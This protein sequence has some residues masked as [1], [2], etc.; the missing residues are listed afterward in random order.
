[1]TGKTVRL[2]LGLRLCGCF[3]DFQ[4]K[5]PS[6]WWKAG[7]TC[8]RTWVEN[9]NLAGRNLSLCWHQEVWKLRWYQAGSQLLVTCGTKEMGCWLT[10]MWWLMM[11]HQDSHDFH[12]FSLI[13]WH[14]LLLEIYMRNGGLNI[15][16]RYTLEDN[17]QYQYMFQRQ[18]TL[19]RNIEASCWSNNC[20]ENGTSSPEPQILEAILCQQLWRR[21]TL[22]EPISY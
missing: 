21:E 7:W 18:S 10:H 14:A 12:W 11:W 6:G 13:I 16:Q 15:F 17:L 2:I 22:G 19:C 1:M 9:S 3:T 8:R 20:R 5:T 4:V